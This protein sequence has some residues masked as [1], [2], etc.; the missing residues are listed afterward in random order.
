MLLVPCIWSRPSAGSIM[1]CT[2]VFPSF[3]D[4]LSEPYFSS[5]I[6]KFIHLDLKHEL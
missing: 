2:L 3:I 4:V 5:P 1:G 6:F